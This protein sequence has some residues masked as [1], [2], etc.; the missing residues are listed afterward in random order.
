MS[1]VIMFSRIFPKGHPKEGQS[2]DFI[3][4]IWISINVPLPCSI[5]A[6]QLN[7]EMTKLFLHSYK[8]KH[9]TIRKGNRFRVGDKFSPRI[10]SGKP[11]LSKQIIIADDIEVKKT[12][13]IEI[14]ENGII[15]ING[16]YIHEDFTDIMKFD[17]WDRLA[18]NDGLS[19]DD[20]ICWFD[21]LPFKGQ[22]ICWNENVVY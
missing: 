11:Y 7:G 9:H 6:D 14:D 17:S 1:K 20:F 18:L 12:W 15:S 22:I 3:Q 13:N 4:K 19:T 16:K 21:K 8:P 2:T 10:W 5:H